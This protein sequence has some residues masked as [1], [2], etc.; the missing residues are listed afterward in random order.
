MMRWCLEK[1]KQLAEVSA[2]VN[3]YLIFLICI[4]I[5]IKLL[6]L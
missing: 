1:F 4:N 3:Q 2:Q 5:L 6:P